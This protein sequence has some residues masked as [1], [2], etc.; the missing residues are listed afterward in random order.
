MEIFILFMYQGCVKLVSH[1]KFLIK[2]SFLL[3]LLF[4][5]KHF[6]YILEIENYLLKLNQTN[7][8]YPSIEK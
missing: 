8:K 2:I 4:Q 3:F 7:M 5:Q 1:K 6:R